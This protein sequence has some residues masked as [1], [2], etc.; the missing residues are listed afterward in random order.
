MTRSFEQSKKSKIPQKNLSLELGYTEKTNATPY[1]VPQKS[2][3]IN[4][5]SRIQMNN[6]DDNNSEK[7][8]TKNID[9]SQ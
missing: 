1:W 8:Y 3:T 2:A 6:Y 5:L 9:R 7:L 4:D